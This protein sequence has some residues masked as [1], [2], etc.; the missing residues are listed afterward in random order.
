MKI[1]HKVRNFIANDEIYC[2]LFLFLTQKVLILQNI[3]KTYDTTEA[4]PDKLQEYT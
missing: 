3:A 4:I 2:Q 1:G